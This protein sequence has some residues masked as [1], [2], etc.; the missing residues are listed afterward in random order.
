MLY[1][2]LGLND[3]QRKLFDKA[4]ELH[5][6]QKRKYTGE[7]YYVHLA[8]VI[9][10]LRLCAADGESLPKG[11]IEVAICHDLLED[12]PFCNTLY[13]SELFFELSEKKPFDFDK[14]AVIEAIEWLTEKYTS[15]D[16][17]NLNRKERKI[18]ENDRLSGFFDSLN[19][20][21]NDPCFEIVGCVKLADM[22]SNTISISEHDP[23]FA[24]VYL[25]E[26]KHLLR[27]F[28]MNK[29]SVNASFLFKRLHGLCSQMVF[30]RKQ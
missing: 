29:E 26:K 21:Y 1:Q 19:E 23:S 11:F 5:G 4:I 22:I 18:L 8:E 25:Q 16:Y 30:E 7:P 9:G 13:L 10:I 24:K 2:I 14:T 20:Y 17:L 6:N 15:K 28:S 27:L 3:F 12:V